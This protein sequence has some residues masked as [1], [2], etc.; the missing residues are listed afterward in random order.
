MHLRGICGGWGFSRRTICC[1]AL[2]GGL[3]PRTATRRRFVARLK[4]QLWNR[5]GSWDNASRSSRIAGW[6]ATRTGRDASGRDRSTKQGPHG[7]DG[8]F[9][10]AILPQGRRL[11]V[12]MSDPHA[13]AGIHP[14]DR[15]GP[16]RRRLHAELGEQRVPRHSRPRLRPPVRARVP[17]RPRRGEAGRHLP[18]EARRRRLQ[19]RYRRLHAGHSGGEERQAHRADRRRPCLAHRGA[20]SAAAR[21][22]LRAV[23]EGPQGRRPDAH[24]HPLLPPAGDGARRGGRPHRRASASRRASATRS[25]ASRRC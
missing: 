12:G 16:L 21:L 25:R 17:P 8:R 3:G 2:A 13:R 20:R 5:A 15:A 6:E 1:P 22:H 18:P 11:P 24:Q 4:K 23:R 10:S 7:P 19:G 14:A 9:Q